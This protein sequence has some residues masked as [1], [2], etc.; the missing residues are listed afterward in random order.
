MGRPQRVRQPLG[1]HHPARVR[2]QHDEDGART[3]PAYRDGLALA[4]DLQRAEH[5]ESHGQQRKRQ[6]FWCR[7]RLRSV[8]VRA[9]PPVSQTSQ[10]KLNCH[11]VSDEA[12]AW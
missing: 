12:S 3:R 2:E 6:N 7:V 9:F 4:G 1:R 8:K 10:P 5:A 11:R